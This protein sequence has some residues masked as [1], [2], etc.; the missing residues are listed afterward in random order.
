MTEYTFPLISVIILNYNGFPWLNRCVGSLHTQTIFPNIEI[1]IVDNRSND[2]SDRLA[3]ELMA[4]IPNGRFIQNGSNLG[5]SEGNNRAVAMARGEYLFFL[6]NDA[7]VEPNALEV[8]A[9]E[10]ANSNADAAGP[11]ILN[12]DD[13]SFQSSGAQGFDFFGL[14]SGRREITQVGPLLMPEGCAYFVRRSAFEKV[15]RFD[16]KLFMY[17][18]EYDLSWKLWIAGYK[19]ISVPKAK[20]HHRG[21]AN[22]NPAGGEKM[23]ELRTSD[24]KRYYTNRNTLL[25][26]LKNAQH[27]L[28]PLVLLQLLLLLAE[29]LVSLLLIRRWSFIQKAYWEA[30][31]DCAKMRSYIFKERSSVRAFRKITD[32]QMLRFM[33]AKLNRIEEIKRI[34]R[35]GPPKVI[36]K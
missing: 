7:W 27:V 13:N 20:I 11:L 33:S 36:R 4:G 12:Y 25:V 21:A 5:F 17:A 9:H 15:G 3:E 2:G 8:L 14:P 6:N 22:V 16:S 23:I 32:F 19:I 18:E 10:C 34:I 24:T 35:F 28:L 29:A 1:I 30:I 26:L 31:S